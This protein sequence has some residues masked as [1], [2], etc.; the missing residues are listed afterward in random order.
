MPPVAHAGMRMRSAYRC[1]RRG[2]SPYQQAPQVCAWHG[3]TMSSR[4]CVRHSTRQYQ[5][6]RIETP[7]HEHA[8]Q[9]PPSPHR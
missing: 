6:M 5:A 9:L 8:L 1:N 2:L 4:P 3:R 7:L